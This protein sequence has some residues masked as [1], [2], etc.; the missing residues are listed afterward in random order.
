M[1]NIH[2]VQGCPS[3]IPPV[4]WARAKFQML[5]PKQRPK[6]RLG[7]HRIDGCADGLMFNITGYCTLQT[8]GDSNGSDSHIFP[9]KRIKVFL[10]G[11]SLDPVPGQSQT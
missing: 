8:M 11:S 3:V 7:E 5:C 1:K 6:Q 9:L 4:V 2:W 10:I